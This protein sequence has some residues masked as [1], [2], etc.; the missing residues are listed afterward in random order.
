MTAGGRP[1][2]ARVR[3][4]PSRTPRWR[5]T[6]A[7]PFWAEPVDA[8]RDDRPSAE[9]GRDY[10]LALILGLHGQQATPRDIDV[11]EVVV[12]VPGEHAGEHRLPLGWIV[13][14]V[15][16]RAGDEVGRIPAGVDVD[17]SV[18]DREEGARQVVGELFVGGPGRRPG[19]RAIEIG[20][21]WPQPRARFR[22]GRRQAGDDDDPPGDLL[23]S[24][25]PDELHRRDLPGVLVAVVPGEDEHRRPRIR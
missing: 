7:R 20:S 25:F 1:S 22:R 12:R 8:P 11:Q 16:V 15:H 18:R 9:F 4:S 10:D 3:T 19:E 13:H 5:R 21:G 14:D 24:Q 6:L 17:D 23:R 2:D